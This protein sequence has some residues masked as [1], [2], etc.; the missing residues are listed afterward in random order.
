MRILITTD[1]FAPHRGGGV[2]VVV[3]EVAHR[4]VVAGHDVRILTMET[5]GGPPR[6]NMNGFE[7]VR[8]PSISLTKLVGLQLT[9]SPSF[10]WNIA[11]ELADFAPDVVNV[12]NL[13]FTTTLLA[14]PVARK[15]GI[16]VITTLHLGE[17]T[18]ISGWKGRAAAAYER[19]VGKRVLR[20]SDHLIAVSEAVAAHAQSLGA[21]DIPIDVIPNGVDLTAYHPA[22]TPQD[23]SGAVVGI[24]VGRLLP[25]KGP[26][27]LLKALQG[28]PTDLD[29]LIRIAGDGPMQD[30]LERTVAD[31]GL[32]DRVEFLGL[33]SD[34][35]DLMRDAD[36]FVRPSTL[37]G[38]PL[39]VLEAMASGIPV[40]AT[41]V[42]GTGEAVVD[43]ETGILI[44]PGDIKALSGALENMIRNE[45][46]RLEMGAA[47][48][49]RA[50]ESFSWDRVAERSLEVLE[51]AR[52]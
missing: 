23:R 35:P 15:A 49:R 46:T 26:Q 16:P 36:F 32:G 28:L 3:E 4:Y 5:A 22:A 27:Y 45:P 43:G 2:E 19:A 39:T 41:N 13:F 29:Y 24:F 1:Y 50:E 17:V 44:E 25:N 52:R 42:A 34:I 51:T 18:M 11:K 38:M 31:R 9:I 48:R 40:I 37:E 21:C 20:R 7:V 10:R 8:F 30:E 47:G 12:H 6:E 14:A 33:R